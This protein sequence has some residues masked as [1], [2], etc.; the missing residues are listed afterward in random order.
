M[1]VDTIGPGGSQNHRRRLLECRLRPIDMPEVKEALD[2]LDPLCSPPWLVQLFRENVT[3][4]QPAEVLLIGADREQQQQQLRGAFS[5][6]LCERQML[7]EISIG[8]L[9]TRYW[10]TRPGS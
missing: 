2:L 9:G 5:G 1:D 8:R 4:S 3:L 7:A 6:N 10:R